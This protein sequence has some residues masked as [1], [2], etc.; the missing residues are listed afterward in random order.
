M[1]CPF[2]KNSYTNAS[3][4]TIH[5]ESGTCSSGLDRHK[6]NNIVRR[7][8]RNNVIINPNRMITMPGQDQLFATERAWNGYFY[9]CYLCDREF[10][11]L[12]A[13]NQHLKSPAHEQHIYR[14]PKVSCGRQ[15]KLLSRLV[16]HVESESCGV[17]R[18]A[19]VQAQAKG[20]LQNMVGR[21]ISQ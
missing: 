9:E 6:I 11:S 10:N 14:C 12:P 4:L 19:R 18:F 15:Y 20:G 7:M 13:L 1:Q 5:L 16:Q 8:D 2:C 3:G 17:M 21:M